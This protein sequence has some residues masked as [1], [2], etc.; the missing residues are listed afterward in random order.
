MAGAE[1]GPSSLD[2]LA[3]D[4]LRSIL[5][6]LENGTPTDKLARIGPCS[7]RFAV[8]LFRRHRFRSQIG[9]IQYLTQCMFFITLKIERLGKQREVLTRSRYW[10]KRHPRGGGNKASASSENNVDGIGAIMQHQ[11]IS[12]SAQPSQTLVQSPPEEVEQGGSRARRRRTGLAANRT[13]LRDDEPS[14]SSSHGTQSSTSAPTGPPPHPPHQHFPHHPF[15]YPVYIVYPIPPPHTGA[16]G[17]SS[18]STIV[19][20]FHL[21]FP[22]PYSN[23]AYQ[24]PPPPPPS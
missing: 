1:L 16:A 22:F 7:I 19:P 11:Q 17:S 10:R 24:F 6:K 15:P 18:S 23:L 2:T 9:E 21:L 14:S 13:R 3:D 20:H 12:Q 4:E 5:G 8:V